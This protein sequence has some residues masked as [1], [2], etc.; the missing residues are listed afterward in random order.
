MGALLAAAAVFLG[1]HLLVSGT[2]LRGI[3]VAKIG[4]NPYLGLFALSSLGAI[5]WLCIAY[6]HAYASADNRA[7]FDLGQGFRDAAIPVM[8]IAFAL[9]VPG[10][11]MSNP[12][13]ARQEK[14]AV[15]GVLRITRHPFLWGTAIWAGYHL[16]ATTTLA[17]AIF[18]GTFLILALLGTRAIDGKCRRRHGPEWQ[19]VSYQTSNIPFVAILAGR[20]HFVAR[21]YFDWRFAA[22]VVGFVVFLLIHNTL[23][24]MSPFP[25]AWLPF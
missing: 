4:E 6:G 15:R 14:A 21:E 7:L 22:T 19:A 8:A 5:V 9:A 1:I 17:S 24:G 23:F 10:I 25:N 11:L 18:F 12:T 20:N 16:L 2:K 3:I 13:S